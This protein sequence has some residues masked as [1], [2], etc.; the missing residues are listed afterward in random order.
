MAKKLGLKYLSSVWS[1][2][3]LKWISRKMDFFKIGSG[4][5]NA[6]EIINEICK[7]KKPIILSTGLSEFKEVEK[8]IKFIK[9]RNNFYKKKEN[10]A[11]LQCTSCYPII[12]MS[13]I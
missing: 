13:L 12:L 7:Y 11:I 10:I 9:S 8:T 4:D 6:Y 1:K 2:K 5:L 3:D